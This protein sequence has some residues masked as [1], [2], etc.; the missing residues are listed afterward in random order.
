MN[1]KIFLLILV[2]EACS[3]AE[4]LFFK[5]GA[6]TLQDHSLRGAKNYFLFIRNLLAT[7]VMWMAF[8][9]TATAWLI[10]FTVLASVDLSIAVPVDSMQYIMILIASYFFLKERMHWT[11]IVGTIFILLGVLFIANS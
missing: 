4:Q 6:D 3:T 5:K 1:L 10:W 8:T 9:M 7:P 11:R 2:H